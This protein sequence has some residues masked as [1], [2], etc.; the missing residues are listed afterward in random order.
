MWIDD[1]DE[2]WV[3]AEDLEIGDLV[4]ALDGDYGI[5]EATLTKARTQ[6]MYDLDVA[7]VDNFAVG[8]GVVAKET[9]VLALLNHSLHNLHTLEIGRWKLL[10]VGVYK[11]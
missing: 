1:T 7:I 2:V 4:L 11:K 6:T 8:D 10:L 3:D 5:V 9:N